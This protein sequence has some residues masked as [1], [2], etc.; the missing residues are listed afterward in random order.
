MYYVGSSYI[1]FYSSQSYLFILKRIIW[2][3]QSILDIRCCHYSFLICRY[4]FSST[5]LIALS[6]PRLVSSTLPFHLS[7]PL[8]SYLFSSHLISTHILHFLHAINLFS[9]II[10]TNSSSSSSFLPSSTSSSTS[11]F[12]S[13]SFSS[14]SSFLYLFIYLYFFIFFTYFFFFFS[15]FFILPD[16]GPC[17]STK[18]YQQLW[19]HRQLINKKNHRIYLP[20]YFHDHH[21]V[22]HQSFH[23]FHFSYLFHSYLEVYSSHH[24]YY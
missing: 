20:F 7:S 22:P 12:S 2:E 16:R 13:T 18:Y 5:I 21:L 10:L 4:L 1:L 15:F 9:I 6:I 24:Y 17:P 8:L 23:L 19:E 3:Q 14:S 11:T